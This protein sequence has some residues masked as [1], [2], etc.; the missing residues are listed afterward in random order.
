MTRTPLR[1]A[2][3]A[4]LAACLLSASLGAGA[5]EVKIKLGTVAPQGSTW[6]ELLKDMAV[7]WKDASGG[8]VDLKIYAGGTQ[9]NEGEMVKKLAIGQL[10]A[11]SITV[12]GLRDISPEPQA[13]GCPGVIDS[14]EEYDYVHSKMRAELE[15]FIQARGYVVLNWAEAGFVK[16]FSK[17]P[18]T[19]VAEFAKGKVFAWNGDPDAEEAWKKAG[20]RPVLLASTDL[21]PSLQTNMVDI[22]TEPPLYAYT[23]GFYEKAKYMLDL[24]WGFLNGATVVKKEQ[25]EKIPADLRPKLLAIAEAT[26]LKVQ[27]EVRLKAKESLDQMKAK[28]LIV[29][30]PEKMEEWKAA[31]KAV[32]GVVRGKVVKEATFDKVLKFRDEY[33]AAKAAGTVPGAAA[34]APAP[35]PE[36]AATPAAAPAAAPAEAR[37]EHAEKAEHKSKKGSG[38]QHKPK[39][40]PKPAE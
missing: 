7:Q 34:P 1:L 29:Q 20:L 27:A 11:A 2:P 24:N 4:L 23:S 32:Q 30:Q 3:A 17:T 12:V 33:R 19:T 16:I 40:V 38:S 28:G 15:S 14:E 39:P 13:E 21:I 5:Q 36:P 37:P 22:V 35:A 25:W 10:H 31:L 9:G 18:R 6:H 26:G 8:K